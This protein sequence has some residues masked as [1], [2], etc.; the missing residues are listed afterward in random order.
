MPITFTPLQN[1]IFQFVQDGTGHGII[2]ACAGS[3]KTTTIIE[4]A[5][6]VK[7]RRKTLFCAFNRSIRIEIEG[8]FR[9]KHFSE[10][11]VKTMHALG[12]DILKSKF[13]G[14]KEVTIDNNK[15]LNVAKSYDF[16]HRH[17]ADLTILYNLTEKQKIDD[18][19][20]EKVDPNNTLY[21][22]DSSIE[23][24]IRSFYYYLPEA[25]RDLISRVID[26]NLRYRLTLCRPDKDEF[27]T[28][29]EHFG[30]PLCEQDVEDEELPEEVKAY[31]SYLNQDARPVTPAQVLDAYFNINSHLMTADIQLANHGVVDFADMLYLP[32]SSAWNLTPDD[33]FDFVF[34]DECQ[35]LSRAQL[36]IAKKYCSPEGRILAVGDPQQSIYGFAGADSE[37]FNRIRTTLNAKELPLSDCFRCPQTV[38][39][40]AKPYK[41]SISG[42]KDY[43]GVVEQVKCQSAV[44]GLVKPGNMI[45]SRTKENLI[46]MLF[47][48][49]DKEIKCYIHQ[50]NVEEIIEDL[51]RIFT[52]E[53]RTK[54]YDIFDID[55]SIEVIMRRIKKQIR[56]KYNNYRFLTQDVK[57]EHITLEI[58][59][60]QSRVDYIFMCLKKWNNCSTITDVLVQI[61]QI[62]SD[63]ADDAIKLS[64]VHRAKGLENDVVF[65]LAANKLPLRWEHMQPWQAIQEDNLTYVAYTRAKEKLYLVNDPTNVDEDEYER[66][67]KGAIYTDP[68]KNCHA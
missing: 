10:I 45:I 37:S 24:R 11:T 4:C 18:D 2:D 42:V 21:G 30:F 52:R 48:L 15:L 29:L 43:P 49:L 5:N 6:Y 25:M 54:K 13:Y 62:I 57:E 34:V 59:R 39:E 58:E 41:P 14:D 50:D 67:I 68:G 53:E 47:V 56:G 33:L 55:H 26:I 46:D 7:D 23:D 38:I 35:D 17:E 3:G 22:N 16:I 28:M 12:F 40:L 20:W 51:K 64:T 32:S 19:F 60:M 36:E 31:L 65:L 27:K 61:K 8:K 63:K 1:A 66:K 9:K 44:L